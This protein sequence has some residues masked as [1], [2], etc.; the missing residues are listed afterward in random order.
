ML[1][2]MDIKILI[3]II[4]R[5]KKQK[6]NNLSKL[7]V[8]TSK[9]VKCFGTAFQDLASIFVPR[10]GIPSCFSSAEW[11]RTEFR[12]FASIFVPRN[13]IPSFFPCRGIVRNKIPRVC[14]YFCST[15]QNSGHFSLP[16]NGSER[17]SESFLLS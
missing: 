7:F 17:N 2:F 14:F 13:G 8:S 1:L 15:V 4:I 6:E 16:R 3:I 9:V 5:F 11:F 10:N 12:E